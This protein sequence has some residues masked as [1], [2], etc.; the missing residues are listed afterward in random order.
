MGSMD[1]RTFL[2]GGLGLG[3]LVL[4]GGLARADHYQQ[5]DAVW[6]A[7]CDYTQSNFDDPIVYKNQPGL[8]HRHDYFGTRA[9]AFTTNS[10][11]RAQDP[12][13][14]KG[15]KASFGPEDD[16][17]SAYWVPAIDHDGQPIDMSQA[18]LDAY[19]FLGEH[20]PPVKPWPVGLRMIAGDAGATAPQSLSVV[21]MRCVDNTGGQGPNEAAIPDC[22]D[23]SVVPCRVGPCGV[24]D[25]VVIVVLFP[26]CW[27]GVNLDTVKPA[28]GAPNSNPVTGQVYPNDHKS[29]MA[30]PQNSVCPATHPVKTPKLSMTIRYRGSWQGGPGSTFS[31]GG[32]YSAHADFWNAWT[33]ARQR[34]LIDECLNVIRNCRDPAP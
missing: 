30:Y 31:S 1:R 26:E 5:N 23:P 11:L 3:V 33:P 2:L 32:V 14:T 12:A 4:A 19:Y 24:L 7:K 29:H 22:T 8:A 25:T 27:D 28:S 6:Q 34:F 20:H 16:D 9:D 21:K 17:R 13:C 10:T 18:S 15:S